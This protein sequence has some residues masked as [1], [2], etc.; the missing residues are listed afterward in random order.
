M[1]QGAFARALTIADVTDRGGERAVLATTRL[2]D[3]RSRQLVLGL[4]PRDM[5]FDV[6]PPARAWR[7]RLAPD[8]QASD[9]QTLGYP[10]VGFVEQMHYQPF[11][12]LGTDEAV[13]EAA[14]GPL[15]PLTTRNVISINQWLAPVA[16]TEVMARL[17]ELK[18][19]NPDA[20]PPEAEL[21]RLTALT[22][23]VDTNRR[24]RRHSIALGEG[25]W[26]RVG[27]ACA[28]RAAR[29]AL[30]SLDLLPM[31]A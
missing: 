27:R 22:P 26:P 25:H 2:D 29:R 16:R 4:S 30:R 7:L 3:E 17:L 23:D 9:G 6:Q 13:W 10:W 11:I 15:L 14:G 24:P 28:G 1:A 8:L 31:G 19:K 5:G 12:A 21:R 18:R 20:A